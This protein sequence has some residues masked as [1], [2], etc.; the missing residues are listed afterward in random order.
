M[1]DGTNRL[2][3]LRDQ[4][5]GRQKNKRSL[6]FP[7]TPIEAKA[8]VAQPYIDQHSNCAAGVVAASTLKL[9]C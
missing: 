7:L 8:P 6:V 2:V 1:A 4:S 3:G 9:E 5:V